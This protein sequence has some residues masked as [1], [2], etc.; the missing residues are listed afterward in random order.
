MSKTGFICFGRFYRRKVTA[1]FLLWK[2]FLP[3]DWFHALEPIGNS[4]PCVIEIITAQNYCQNSTFATFSCY[5][6][7]A[8]YWNQS[9][10]SV[11]SKREH[12]KGRRR[13]ASARFNDLKLLS[14]TIICL[15][16]NLRSIL[17]ADNPFLCNAKASPLF[18]WLSHCAHFLAQ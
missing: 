16:T 12:K 4:L 6:I 18:V 13:R 15:H 2:A 3:Q 10:I 14:A 8:V 9:W 7:G 11:L 5:N 17:W 1:Y